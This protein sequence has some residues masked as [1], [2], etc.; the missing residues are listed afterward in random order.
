MFST[1]ATE[2]TKLIDV[3]F[4]A[5]VSQEE[6]KRFINNNSMNLKA[7][8]LTSFP[9]NKELINNSILDVRIY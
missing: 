4:I 9:D 5:G 8:I 7:D 2:S 1:N 6:I 3:S